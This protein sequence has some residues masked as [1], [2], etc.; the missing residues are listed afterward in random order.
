MS[1]NLLPVRA[2]LNRADAEAALRTLEASGIRGK[3]TD[4]LGGDLPFMLQVA[5]ADH[6]RAVEILRR[7]DPAAPLCE[8]CKRNPATMHLTMIVDGH[9]TTSNFCRECYE[10]PRG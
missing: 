6:D 9:S 5:A 10:I 2:Y 3:L 1:A 4:E 7:G 8:R